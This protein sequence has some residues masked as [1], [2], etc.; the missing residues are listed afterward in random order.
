MSGTKGL[1]R[2]CRLSLVL[3]TGGLLA[4]GA[5]AQGPPGAPEGKSDKSE[6]KRFKDVKDVTEDMQALDGLFTLYRFDPSDK[7]K[8]PEKL[9]AR[10]PARLINEDLLF[11]TSIARGGNFTGWMWADYLFRWQVIGD[12]LVMITPDTRYIAKKEQPIAGA[13]EATYG[14]TWIAALPILAMSPQGDVVVDFEKLLKTDIA[15]VAGIAGGQIRPELSRWTKVKAFPDN[16]LIETDLAAA[17]GRSGG[18]VGVGYAF[19]RLPKLG[20]YSPRASDPRIGYF[21]TTRV[22]WAKPN[23]EREVAERYVN[24]WQLE[25]RDPSL[26]LSPPKKP[27][28]FIV[29]K[30]TPIQWRRW[31]RDGVLEWNRAFE[32]IGFVDAIVVQQQTDDN[33]YASYDP[34]DARYNFVRWTVTGRALAVGPSRADPRTGQ[35]LDADIVMDDAWVRYFVTNVD[36]FTSGG[37]RSLLGPGFEL[38]EER[39]PDFIPHVLRSEP[40]PTDERQ[41][42]ATLRAARENSNCFN[43]YVCQHSCSY[44]EGMA[45]EMALAHAA[46]VASGLGKQIPERLIGE[47]VKEVVTHEVG[48]TL[49]LRHNFKASSWLTLDEIRQRRD[50]GDEP[51]T[52]SMV[53]Y[54][55]LVLF[56]VVDVST[57]GHFVTPTIGPYDELAIEYGYRL[58]DKGE[59]EDKLLKEIAA[60]QSQK[61]NDYAT[62]EDTVGSFSPDPFSNRYDMGD[63]PAAWARTRL[64]MC[65]KLL[66][67]LNEWAAKE[68]DPKHYLTQAFNTL[69]TQKAR[70]FE[71][72]SRMLGGQR[73]HRD[74]IGD[75]D[76]R[77][78]LVLLEPQVQ[79]DAL[80]VLIESLLDDGFGNVPPELLNNL[81]P[82]RWMDFADAGGMR[83]DY[84][85]HDRVL[86]LQLIGVMN[87][88]SPATLQRVY[89]AEAKTTAKDKFTAAELIVSMRDAVWRHL[90]GTGS[91]SYTDAQPFIRATSRNLQ[92]AYTI[93]MLSLAQQLPG[94]GMS[95]DLNNMVRYA[96]QELSDKIDATLKKTDGR[97]GKS[98]LDFA[99]R[100]HLSQT[101]S[102]IDR[103]LNAQYQA[104]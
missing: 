55:P 84:P 31:V 68:G 13:I 53:D 103:V 57:E 26:E 9:L 93:M 58:P 48:H 42:F 21:T 61:G 89:D 62:D 22:D 104:R 37:P 36:V 10:I 90:D 87:A 12:Q 51:T 71:Y 16:L 92:R 54:I 75:P 27:I 80:K 6:K 60:R 101:K 7:N 95:P 50:A 96:L 79:R 35:I 94:S 99:S 69:I 83:I 78:A 86:L 44:A 100:A 63:D 4:A 32:K 65:D 18:Y 77:P 91:G 43:P 11:A 81:P 72:V 1:A 59:R 38:L 67:T 41:L 17:R 47:A 74:H 49:G 2:W 73:Y 8:D 76:G 40:S 24:R 82:S 34:E 5:V 14:D 29:E 39:Y 64:Q 19:Q 88:C 98:R 52:A 28:T 30:T 15:G 85:I 46:M 70:N 3:A 66:S 33:E 102:H 20:S 56:G 97:D 45:L 23:S 25:K